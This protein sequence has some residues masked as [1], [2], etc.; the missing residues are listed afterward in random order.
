[1]IQSGDYNYT[2]QGF[3]FSSDPS[4]IVNVLGTFYWGNYFDGKLTATDVQMQFAPIPHISIT[5]HLNRN[6]FFNVAQ[7]QATEIID[8]YSL[9][10][11][12]ALNPR[13]QLIAFYQKTLK[14]IP[15]IITSASPGNTN[16][17]PISTLFIITPALILFND[18]SYLKIT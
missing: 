10:A 11:R 6:H 3:W 15:L 5:G 8:L 14:T 12:L 16:L 13:V 1:M 9:Q 2:R 7:P 17:Y 18:K 4:K